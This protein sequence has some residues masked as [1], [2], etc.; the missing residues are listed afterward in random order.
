MYYYEIE[1]SFQK[2]GNPPYLSEVYLDQF[3]IAISTRVFKLD[4]D[5]LQCIRGHGEEF[6]HLG[7]QETTFII[8]SS[9]PREG[10]SSYHFDPGHA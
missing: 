1:H 9:Q 7:P 5:K 6:Y 8:L 10:K 2:N 3:L 4:G